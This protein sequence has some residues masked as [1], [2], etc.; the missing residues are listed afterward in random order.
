MWVFIWV[1]IIGFRLAKDLMVGPKRDKTLDI[2]RAEQLVL[3][4]E[5]EFFDNAT[6]GNMHD[7]NMKLAMEW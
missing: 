4:A 5:Q 7:G 1:T 3:D 2:G 6:T